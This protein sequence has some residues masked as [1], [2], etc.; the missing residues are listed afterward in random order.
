MSGDLCSQEGSDVKFVPLFVVKL[1]ASWG[2][3][4]KEKSVESKQKQ[5]WVRI[6]TVNCCDEWKC[7]VQYTN[8][9]CVSHFSCQPYWGQMNCTQ[10]CSELESVVN[11]QYHC[12]K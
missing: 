5:H 9:S 1:V 4:C 7:N 8:W 10:E 2:T 12:P 11:R 3:R 6:C